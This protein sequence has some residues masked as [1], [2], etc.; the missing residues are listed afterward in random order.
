MQSLSGLQENWRGQLESSTAAIGQSVG[1]LC[2]A[3]T[4]ACYLS[5]AEPHALMEVVNVQIVPLLEERGISL[6]W[7]TCNDFARAVSGICDAPSGFETSTTQDSLG[8]SELN[9]KDNA[10]AATDCKAL[11]SSS[12]NSLSWCVLS[13]MIPESLTDRWLAAPSLCHSL[14]Y[15][16]C[17]A[18]IHTSWN[19]WPLV[20]DPQDLFLRCMQECSKELVMLDAT[21][22]YINRMCMLFN[23]WPLPPLLN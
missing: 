8:D 21:D 7:K 11:L 16:L 9:E 22:R 13:H 2:I 15:M 17:S 10:D 23:N 19:K 12:Y 18:L 4:L 6:Y 1:A 5:S 14:S 3:A 20:Y